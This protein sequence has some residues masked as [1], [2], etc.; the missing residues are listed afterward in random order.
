MALK[1]CFPTAF[2]TELLSGTHDFTS[3][4]FKIALYSSSATLNESTTAYT[5][6]G[7]VV[8]SGYTAGGA[9]LTVT[10]PSTLGTTVYVDFDDVSWTSEITARGALIY[11][12]SQSNKAVYVLDFGV[13]RVHL[14]GTFTISFPV[15]TELDAIIR[16]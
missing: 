4:T 14:D 1:Q 5:A 13:D 12:S 8:A 3:D 6:T 9:A 15:P 2:K 10:G 16:I 11:N 7:E